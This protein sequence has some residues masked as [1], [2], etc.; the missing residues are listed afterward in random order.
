MGSLGRG[1]LV[2]GSLPGAARPAAALVTA[3]AAAPAA[4]V[5]VLRHR[6]MREVALAAP[7]GL[8]TAG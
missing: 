5:R 3:A 4:T 1:L 2:L 8:A 6:R 7:R